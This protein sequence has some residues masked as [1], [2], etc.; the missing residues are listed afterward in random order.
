MSANAPASL[1]EI[2]RMNALI[3]AQD[4]AAVYAVAWC[5]KTGRAAPTTATALGRLAARFISPDV[6]TRLFGD[7]GT[8]PDGAGIEKAFE[9]EAFALLWGT[10][11]L[12]AS[13]ADP[14][15][16][17]SVSTATNDV[18]QTNVKN[19]VHIEAAPV[20][21]GS[22]APPQPLYTLPKLASKIRALAGALPPDD[23]ASLVLAHVALSYLPERTCVDVLNMWKKPHF[24]G[25]HFGLYSTRP[26]TEQL[27]NAIGA[28]RSTVPSAS[29][30][31]AEVRSWVIVL[32][33]AKFSGPE[34][35]VARTVVPLHGTNGEKTREIT[36]N[37]VLY[38]VSDRR[39]TA[40][41]YSATVVCHLGAHV[42]NYARIFGENATS[43]Q[44]LVGA[45]T[46]PPLV[47]RVQAL[48]EA[49]NAKDERARMSVEMQRAARVGA[50]AS[51]DRLKDV[52]EIAPSEV[53]PAAAPRRQRRATPTSG[54]NGAAPDADAINAATEAQQAE[55]SAPRYVSASGV[56]VEFDDDDDDDGAAA[57]DSSP[58]RSGD[59]TA[60]SSSSSSTFGPQDYAEIERRR[61][62]LTREQLERLEASELLRKFSA[63]VGLPSH[64]DTRLRAQ[65]LALAHFSPLDKLAINYKRT[66]PAQLHAKFERIRAYRLALEQQ[67]KVLMLEASD[68]DA[69]LAFY[70]GIQHLPE[71]AMRPVNAFVQS[72]TPIL[73]PSDAAHVHSSDGNKLRRYVEFYSS[74]DLTGWGTRYGMRADTAAVLTNFRR[75]HPAMDHRVLETLVALAPAPRGG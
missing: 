6:E 40:L 18:V 15:K 38:D 31:N 69:L 16:S 47:S 21:T 23:A 13:P 56:P 54:G 3:E 66:T 35:I 49:K 7:N 22:H 39:C 4:R 10:L 59:A 75:K 37:G 53:L 25:R 5:A 71:K 11:A 17:F 20:G 19:Y 27:I 73:A 72:V 62:A 9:A 42:A 26:N 48:A 41:P 2:S 29:L 46:A 64:L 32:S 44:T 70:D 74:P 24:L 1:N 51:S 63:D 61:I 45:A 36:L 60:S 55:R 43:V 34:R 68:L 14:A 67:A 12:R 8:T 57:R 52:A 30:T 65:L 28:V 33:M 58:T 50:E